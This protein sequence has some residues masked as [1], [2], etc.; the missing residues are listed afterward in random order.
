[1]SIVFLTFLFEI[2]KINPLP[3]LPNNFVPYAPKLITSFII[4]FIFS[5]I[6]INN[7]VWLAN[8]DAIEASV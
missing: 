5:K 6:I 7:E 8:E 3:P 4:S 1:M 2:T